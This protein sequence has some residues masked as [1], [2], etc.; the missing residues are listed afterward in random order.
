M[1]Q[2]E[3][4]SMRVDLEGQ[5]ALVAASDG[6]FRR[7]MG[8]LLAANGSTVIHGA[9]TAR[10]TFPAAESSG[11][12]ISLSSSSDLATTAS[13]LR[14]DHGRID[15][16]IIDAWR[17]HVDVGHAERL[18]RALA[19]P[20]SA[21]RSGRIVNVVSALGMIPAR[22]EGDRSANAAAIVSL[23]RTLA[24]E[25]A[26][27]GIAVNA[28]AAG[29]IATA[30]EIEMPAP[31]RQQLADRLLSHVPVGRLGNARDIAAAALFLV[32]PANSYMTGHVLAVDGGWL[33][34]YARDF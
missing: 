3:E 1:M 5:V 6:E 22:G 8:D 9:T 25:L 32:D 19:E 2:D 14:D 34:G 26:P 7:I 21:R 31:T 23:T 30:T 20:M 13:R 27:H 10:G 17:D 33:A 15:T 18:C 4:V 29:A 24:M 12:E 28:V 16:L 11:K